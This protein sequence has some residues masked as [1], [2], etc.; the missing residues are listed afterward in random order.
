MGSKV[1]SDGEIF[2]YMCVYMLS[3]MGREPVEQE[4]VELTCNASGLGAWIHLD[5]RVPH[6]GA[7]NVDQPVEP[8]MADHPPSALRPQQRMTEPK[9]RVAGSGLRRGNPPRSVPSSSD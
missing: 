6:V 9:R 1:P 8:E 7:W 3:L 4:L 5:V 2:A